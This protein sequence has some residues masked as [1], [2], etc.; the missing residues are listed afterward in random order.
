MLESKSTIA[1]LALAAALV[2]YWTTLAPSPDKDVRVSG[3]TQPV[4]PVAALAWAQTNCGLQ[5]VL[6]PGTPRLQ[7]EDFIAMTA[8]LDA[9]RNA[10]GAASVCQQAIRLALP[11]AGEEHAAAHDDPDEIAL[12]SH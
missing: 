9:R 8:E 2:A 12:S 7:A 10:A 6:K 1:T 5:A 3:R 4:H 11:V